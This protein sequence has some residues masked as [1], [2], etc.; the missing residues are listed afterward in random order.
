M[1]LTLAEE[2]TLQRELSQL[3]CDV[4]AEHIKLV[5]RVLLLMLLA[6]TAITVSSI[7]YL[8]HSSSLGTN[9]RFRTLIDM[10]DGLR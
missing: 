5:L 4:S 2:G 6:L 3:A 1:D 9:V 8:T 10:D 7:P